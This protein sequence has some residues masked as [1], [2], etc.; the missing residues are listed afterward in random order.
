MAPVGPASRAREPRT[1][2][3][4]ASGMASPR[5]LTQNPLKKI[6]MPYSNGRPALHA[7]QRGGEAGS[8]GS[9]EGR[10]QGWVDRGA[11]AVVLHGEGGREPVRI[12]GQVRLPRLVG[13][14]QKQVVG[15]RQ[16]WQGRRRKQGCGEILAPSGL[17]LA[18]FISGRGP[19]PLALHSVPTASGQ[20]RTWSPCAASLLARE[21]G[22]GNWTGSELCWP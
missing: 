7:C 22:P 8:P 3:P 12:R 9:G 17:G 5:E 18:V 19:S 15:R 13:G 21:R 16:V 2:T 4:P 10:P 1:P 20:G 11:W 6:W 14:E